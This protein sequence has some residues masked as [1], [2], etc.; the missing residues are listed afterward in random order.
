MVILSNNKPLV[1]AYTITPVS[2][3][4]RQWFG[5]VC[6]KSCSPLTTY[7]GFCPISYFFVKNDVRMTKQTKVE[8]ITAV[9]RDFP[10]LVCN[11]TPRKIFTKKVYASGLDRHFLEATNHA[12]LYLTDNSIDSNVFN[13]TYF[14][15]E[16]SGSDQSKKSSLLAIVRLLVQCSPIAFSP[17][18]LKASA[19]HELVFSR[20]C[21]RYLFFAARCS[22]A[23]EDIVGAS[24]GSDPSRSLLSRKLLRA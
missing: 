22:V 12:R 5:A 7:F 23:Q 8:K 6:S 10:V 18:I 17:H 9:R 19:S 21:P 1:E 3:R 11:K 15:G 13:R 16:T 20:K 4:I 2:C 24:H 14:T